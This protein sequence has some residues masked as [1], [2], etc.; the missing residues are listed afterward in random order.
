MTSRSTWNSPRCSIHKKKI[1]DAVRISSIIKT[2]SKLN[3][4]RLNVLLLFCQFRA[5]QAVSP[6]RRLHL[7]FV[8]FRERG[9]TADQLCDFAFVDSGCIFRTS[10]VPSQWHGVSVMWDFHSGRCWLRRPNFAAKAAVAGYLCWL[11]RPAA[12]A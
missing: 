11:R 7:R 10:R 1:Q 2:I 12:A 4:T 9:Q 8:Y 5:Y 6:R 3:S